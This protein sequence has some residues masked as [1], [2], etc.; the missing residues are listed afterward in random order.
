MLRKIDPINIQ[1]RSVSDVLLRVL[2]NY[3]DR[4]VFSHHDV[5]KLDDKSIQLTHTLIRASRH[6]V[7]EKKY[8]IISKIPLGS[9]GCGTVYSIQLDMLISA[10]RVIRYTKPNP[11]QIVKHQFIP[12]PF[13]TDDA[14]IIKKKWRHEYDQSKNG[15]L[16]A[17]IPLFQEDAQRGLDIFLPM[18][19]MPGIE[20]FDFL[21]AVSEPNSHVSSYA[22]FLLTFEL[23]NTFF[24][25]VVQHKKVHGDLKPSN[26]MFAM[27]IQGSYE[28]FILKGGLRHNAKI[29]QWQL[30]IIDFEG[31]EEFGVPRQ[32]FTSTKQYA[33]SETRAMVKQLGGIS[34]SIYP[35]MFNEKLFDSASHLLTN[36]MK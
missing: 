4:D 28:A 9:G 11:P 10:D 3:Q 31:C 24:K 13:D 18:N 22:R 27:N 2:Q 36:I 17:E 32:F 26:M 16:N 21:M 23:L 12:Y 34:H 25:Q 1:N 29:P 30:N 7:D 8:H 35:A 15:H 6:Q 5:F 14:Q 20:F 33:A 19:R